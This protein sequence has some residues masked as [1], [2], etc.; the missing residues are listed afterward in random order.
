MTPTTTNLPDVPSLADMDSGG[1]SA[2]PKGWYSGTILADYTGQSGNT[3]ETNDTDSKKGDSRN[4]RAIIRVVN[5][6]EDEPRT[7]FHNINY[8]DTDLTAERIEEVKTAR[9]TY[10]GTQ[11]RWP[12]PD[13]QRSSLALASLGQ[14]EKAMG[15]TFSRNGN[16]LDVTPLHNLPVDVYLGTDEKGFNEVK[17]IAAQGTRVKT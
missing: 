8:R 4:I 2:W 10:A 13:V 17:Q 3:F 14:V 11:G 9:K 12:D 1:G 7:L 5:P 16:G 15:R 6:N